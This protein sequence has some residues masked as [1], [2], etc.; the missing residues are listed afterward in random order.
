M[1]FSSS[2]LQASA[3]CARLLAISV[4]AVC[5]FL[6]P[7]RAS[8][9]ENGCYYDFVCTKAQVDE[10][11][12]PLITVQM[13]RFRSQ[14]IA[15][16]LLTMMPKNAA[17]YLISKNEPLQAALLDE[18][19]SNL[20][21]LAKLGDFYDICP[22]ELVQT[23]AQVGEFALYELTSYESEV[24]LYGHALIVRMSVVVMQDKKVLKR[25]L[26]EIELAKKNDPVQIADTLDFAFFSE[27]EGFFLPKWQTSVQA[28]EQEWKK[29]CHAAGFSFVKIPENGFATLCKHYMQRKAPLP[30]RF[31]Q[32]VKID[33]ENESHGADLLF[34][35]AKSTSYTGYIFCKQQLL[36]DEVTSSLQFIKKIAS[37]VGIDV[38]FAE[39]KDSLVIKKDAPCV[40]VRAYATDLRGRQWLISEITATQDLGFIYL[41]VSFLISIERV[42]ALLFERFGGQMPLNFAP[43]Q[44]RVLCLSHKAKAWASEVQKRLE[45]ESVRYAY[46]LLE[47]ADQRQVNQAVYEASRQK[48]PICCILG[49]NEQKNRT[50][51]L[52][53]CVKEQKEAHRFE[54][55]LDAFIA[56]F[57]ESCFSH[58]WNIQQEEQRKL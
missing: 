54:V 44:V 5:P 35:A 55:A 48:V 50:V 41:K 15:F 3:S 37:I 27:G 34:D 2:S 22:H 29:E 14:A 25:Q 56:A 9:Y 53:V 26:K 7:L 33:K 28:F 18:I 38:S 32:I 46:E 52:R 45:K 43:E 13:R 57:K 20:V 39:A 23:T 19:D 16:E 10:S 6:I 24:P 47:P 49:E 1:S 30:F 31:A 11:I 17:G 12:L 40:L 36:Q 51:N 42:F 21:Q 8:S 58:A 4:K